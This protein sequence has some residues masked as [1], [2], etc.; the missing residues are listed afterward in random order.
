M[1]EIIIGK[2]YEQAFES[3]V[4]IFNMSAKSNVFNDLIDKADDN[5]IRA[6]NGTVFKFNADAR[7]L[8]VADKKGGL[9]LD[10]DGASWFAN[11]RQGSGFSDGSSEWLSLIDG[12]AERYHKAYSLLEFKKKV[13]KSKPSELE[14]EIQRHTEVI[15]SI[16]EQ[17]NGINLNRLCVSRVNEKCDE[18]IFGASLR[19]ELSGGTGAAVPILCKVY[20]RAKDTHK[21]YMGGA[22]LIPLDSVEAMQVDS[23]LP[24]LVCEKQNGEVDNKDSASIIDKV[25]STMEELCRPNSGGVEGRCFGDC[26]CYSDEPNDIIKDTEVVADMASKLS[27]DN[28]NLECTSIKL[29]GICHV[30]WEKAVYTASMNGDKLFDIQ[31]G[32]GNSVSIKCAK[33]GEQVVD[34]NKIICSYEDENGNVSKEAIYLSADDYSTFEHIKNSE[35]CE[36]FKYVQCDSCNRKASGCRKFVCSNMAFRIGEN[37]EYKCKNCPYPE[38]V[39]TDEEGNYQY[40]P[41]LCFARDKMAMI[42]EDEVVNCALCGRLFSKGIQEH[43]GLCGL[44]ELAIQDLSGSDVA[45]ARKL[46]KRYAEMLSPFVKLKHLGQKKLCFEDEDTIIFRLGNTL[47]IADKLK[48]NEKGLLVSPKKRKMIVGGRLV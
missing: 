8:N 41:S 9:V 10:K 30:K 19:I 26:I 33:C 14:A 48:M 35:L 44:C 17:I 25:V 46:Y 5:V 37:D 34:N 38:V 32:L 47:Y 3:I 16:C 11:F 28:A 40:T 18:D 23:M 21:N 13:T 24:S 20:F 2:E 31:I 39:L 43:D 7:G 1:S 15:Q 4:K 12:V 6:K 29:L 36:H 42:P 45:E 22:P 27:H